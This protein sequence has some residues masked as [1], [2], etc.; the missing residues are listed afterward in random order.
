MGCMDF[1]GHIGKGNDSK[2]EGKPIILKRLLPAAEVYGM[3]WL[4]AGSCGAP[5][6]QSRGDRPPRPNQQ[7]GW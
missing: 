5:A 3:L 1:V 6:V 4:P 7:V 2:S